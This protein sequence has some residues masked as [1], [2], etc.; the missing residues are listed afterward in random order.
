MADQ[1]VVL[2]E[3]VVEQAGSPVELYARP[4]NRFVAGFLGAPQMNFVDARVSRQNGALG[5]GA[6]RGRERCTCPAATLALPDGAPV[7]VGIRPEHA[8]IG[9]GP[10]K[11]KR[12]GDGDSRL[13]DHHPRAA[14]LRRAL[15]AGAARHLRRQAGRGRAAR[16]AA[17]LRASVRRQG[18]CGRRRTRLA[19]RLCEVSGAP[20]SPRFTGEAQLQA[21]GLAG[22]FFGPRG[23]A[24]ADASGG[25]TRR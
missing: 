10:L 17:G 21:V 24:F 16:A 4:A 15:H 18:H 23:A 12:R 20:P 3:G 1:I 19:P 22:G 6:G 13:G 8:E 14:C 2:R 5:A 25:S 11:V 7:T 9:I